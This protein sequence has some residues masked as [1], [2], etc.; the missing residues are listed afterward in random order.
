MDRVK[1]L[2]RAMARKGIKKPK[3]KYEYLRMLNIKDILYYVLPIVKMAKTKPNKYYFG[4]REL[5][6]DQS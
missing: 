5:T 1:A 4:A 2:E 6:F 3:K